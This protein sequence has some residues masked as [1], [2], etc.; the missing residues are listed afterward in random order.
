MKWML[1]C[2]A[3]MTTSLLAVKL[4]EETAARGLDVKVAATAIAEAESSLEGVSA[5]LLGPHVRF[6]ED[7]I[8][9]AAG[10]D[11]PIYVIKPQD[12]GTMN[13]K[14]IVSDVLAMLP[15]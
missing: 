15:A 11:M 1:C 13:V 7:T 2:Y 12:F 3:G 10:P 6:S 4:E 14:A 9:K 8:R 5:V